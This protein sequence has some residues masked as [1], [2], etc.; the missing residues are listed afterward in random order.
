VFPKR[1]SMFR[2]REV[3]PYDCKRLATKLKNTIAES[4]FDPTSE[5]EKVIP[6]A[7]LLS[8]KGGWSRGP[9]AIENMHENILGRRPL[10]T[11]KH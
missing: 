4:S 10:G 7:F 5:K 11:W 6:D 2:G 3:T 8:P 9:G 1:L